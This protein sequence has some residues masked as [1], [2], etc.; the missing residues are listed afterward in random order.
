MA[1]EAP[2]EPGRYA[3]VCFFPDTDDP[4]MTPHAEKGMASEFTVE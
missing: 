1:F 2:L 4:E 3:L